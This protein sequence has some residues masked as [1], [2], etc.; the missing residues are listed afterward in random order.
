MHFSPVFFAYD[1][2]EVICMA[3]NNLNNFPGTISNLPDKP[4]LSG[5]DMKA[6][7]EA[8]CKTL[9]E[10]MKEVIP[11]LNDKQGLLTIITTLFSVQRDNTD[12]Y[13]H[14]EV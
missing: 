4:N 13:I 8:D 6:K 14:T 11:E 10:K 5:A 12:I 1:G 9:W 7:F 3:I 2:H